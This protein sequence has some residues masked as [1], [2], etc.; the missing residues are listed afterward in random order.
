MYYTDKHFKHLNDVVTPLLD[1]EGAV[2][3][4]FVVGLDH[5]S[6]YSNIKKQELIYVGS[7]KEEHYYKFFND[8]GDLL[9]IYCLDII[10]ISKVNY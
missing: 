3:H 10:S 7:D 8:K 9:M 5:I 1:E 4:K 2:G 6:M